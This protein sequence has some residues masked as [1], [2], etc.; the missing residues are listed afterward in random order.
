M[1]KSRRE[2][3]KLAAVA[4]AV[5][6]ISSCRKEEPATAAIPAK[7]AATGAKLVVDIS[8]AFAYVFNADHTRLVLASVKKPGASTPGATCAFVDHAMGISA[9]SVKIVTTLQQMKAADGAIYHM[10][11]EGD[12][13]LRGVANTNPVLA[14]FKKTNDAS[15]QTPANPGAIDWNDI[16]W[17]PLL[18][19]APKD[20]QTKTACRLTLDKGALKIIQ[21][22][23]TMYK[24]LW[25]F[26]PDLRSGFH[27]PN[28]PMIEATQFT[29]DL[30]G[31]TL[32]VLVGS[33]VVATLTTTDPGMTIRI[34][35]PSHT[36]SN[37]T[38]NKGDRIEF[39]SMFSELVDAT[40]A[41][42]D[43]P[44][45]VFEGLVGTGEPGGSDGE[46]CPPGHFVES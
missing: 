26:T 19:D 46:F 38:Y 30:D 22:G 4:G 16:V 27:R 37:R 17:M 3:L 24:G 35:T 2:F 40:R 43:R 33:T 12:V 41:C 23:L 36:T 32:E 15:V 39:Y 14:G 11:P 9:G 8:G 21:P 45:P 6:P 7:A 34:G 20:W 25:S 10:L 29:A 42:A 31:D 13:S 18:G 28:L 5:W 44:V 1:T